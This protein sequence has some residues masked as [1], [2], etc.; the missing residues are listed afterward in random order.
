[1]TRD[2]GGQDRT[3]NGQ[4]RQGVSGNLRGRPKKSR[5]SES[6]GVDGEDLDGVSHHDGWASLL[7]GLGTSRDK[8]ESYHFRGID[9]S[10]HQIAELWAQDAIVA[11]TIEKPSE[12]AFREGYEFTIGNEGKYDDLKEE[13]EERFEE[14]KVD[15][16]LELAWQYKRAYGGATILLGTDDH[17]SLSEPLDESRPL[18]LD[19]LNVFEPIELVPD[20]PSSNLL[21]LGEPEYFRVNTHAALDVAR[22]ARA[23]EERANR[24]VPPP[25][26]RIHSSRLIVFQGIQTSKYIGLQNPISPYWGASVVPRFF[27][28]LRDCGSGYGAVAHLL[29]EG[30]QAILTI[31]GL[32]QMAASRP[33]KF[34]DRME[35]LDMGRTIVRALLL[36]GDEKFERQATNV[37]GYGE[38]LDHQ[39]IYLSAHTDIPLSILFGYSPSSLGQPGETELTLWYNI[40]RAI[41]RR[42]LTP[43]LKR[44]ARLVMRSIRQRKLPKRID[45]T[46]AELVRMT[47]KE[48]AEAELT[49]AR[50][51]SMN[52]KSG[53]L[54]PDEARRSRWKGGYSF[55]TQIDEHKK[56]P[57]FMA[58]M[59]AGV[60]PGSTPAAAVRPG[61][62]AA[63]GPNAHSVT[64]YAR[65]NP[66]RPVLEP[67]TKEGGDKAPENKRDTLRRDAIATY[68]QLA[69]LSELDYQRQQLRQQLAKAIAAEAS[70]ST[71]ALL[72]DLVAL[73]AHEA[74]EPCEG[75]TFCAPRV[76]DDGPGE[77]RLFAG[78]TIVV[79]NARGS[80]REWVDTD[81]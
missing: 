47:V 29:T 48:R 55:K 73:A 52:I 60:L 24:V 63:M 64:S 71:I 26:A 78:L 43:P 66:A 37:A 76:D 2:V 25:N 42:Q 14:L 41:Q 38:L 4:F 54:H 33:K 17:R 1:M 53:M 5:P 72:E 35:A 62:P 51:D 80:T 15:A 11:K 6:S 67:N 45:V 68:A 74:G 40:I 8:R 20:V 10:Y 28:A 32:K 65:R 39:S 22:T 81:G 69:G 30:A 56:A 50:A 23:K 21:T 79:E 75:C 59:P 16:K 7:T 13:V 12:E 3:A 61:S 70:S 57:G 27:A 36:D 77:H 31:P 58:P 46:W 44:I 9:L 19:S 34:F 18:S 49:Q